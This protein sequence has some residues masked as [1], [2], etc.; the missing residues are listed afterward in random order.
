MTRKSIL[1]K[2]KNESIEL[3]IGIILNI[4]GGIF[5][6]LTFEDFS[7]FYFVLAIIFTLTGIWLEIRVLRNH[8]DELKN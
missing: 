8:M 3:T 1:I 4:I 6:G 5:I 2:S 7:I